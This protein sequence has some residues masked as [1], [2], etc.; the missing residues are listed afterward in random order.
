MRLE[1]SENYSE[2]KKKERKSLRMNFG[3]WPG[4]I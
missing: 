2:K 3:E 1:L 4:K